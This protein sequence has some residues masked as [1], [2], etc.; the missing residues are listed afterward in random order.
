MPAILGNVHATRQTPHVATFALLGIILLLMLLGDLGPLAAST[1]LLL[2][3]VFTIVNVG[4]V[5]LKFRP[6]E[7]RGGLEVP[8]I[9]PLLGAIVCAALA[10]YQIARPQEGNH[11]PTYIAGGLVLGIVAMYAILRPKA[12][13]AE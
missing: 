13:L 11:Q 8:F 3:S 4:L 5:I 6:S 12:V 9:V 7:P 1:S 10:G 2:L